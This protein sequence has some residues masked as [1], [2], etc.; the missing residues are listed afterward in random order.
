MVYFEERD[1]LEGGKIQ[2]KHQMDPANHTP[3]EMAL[4]KSAVS[5]KGEEGA[6]QRDTRAELSNRVR[7]CSQFGGGWSCFVRVY[8]TCFDH[9]PVFSMSD[10]CC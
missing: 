6:Q 4:P 10:I 8:L 1:N 5:T 9:R 2:T 7:E 3:E